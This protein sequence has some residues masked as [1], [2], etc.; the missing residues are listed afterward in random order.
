MDYIESDFENMYLNVRKVKIGEDLFEAFPILS[1]YKEFVGKTG[2]LKKELVIRYIAFAFDKRSPLNSIIDIMERR[3]EALKLA[4]F[5]TDAKGRYS[6]FIDMMVHSAVPNINQMVI[7]Y[8]LF[9]G[10]TEYAILVTY[11][12]S[13][14]KE[15]QR[16]MSFENPV[17]IRKGANDTESDEIFYNESNEKK[18]AIITNISNLKKLIGELKKEIFSNN[19]DKFLER[20]LMEFTEAE[21]FELSPEF[22]AKQYKGWDNV[23]RYYA[24]IKKDD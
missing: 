17:R 13:L 9:V 24:Q 19:I 2:N 8:C 11:E 6:K 18:G 14:I 5:K 16:L 3:V 4:G 20:S 21:K 1:R 10:D 15:L 22:Y 12:D 7:R 23:S